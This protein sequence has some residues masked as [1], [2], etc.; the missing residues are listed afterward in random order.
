MHADSEIVYFRNRGCLL[1]GR[2]FQAD[3]TWRDLHARERATLKIIKD[4]ANSELERP[5][6]KINTAIAKERLRINSK[7]DL[8][9]RASL[10]AS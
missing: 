7:V 1:G 9:R 8:G 2:F 5:Q 4:T 6:G 10:Q 3:K